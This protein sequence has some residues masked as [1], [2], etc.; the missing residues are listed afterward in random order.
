MN[1]DSEKFNII[2]SLQSVVL[3]FKA[4]HGT[5]KLEKRE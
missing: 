5:K 2:V 3:V 1:I 4:V